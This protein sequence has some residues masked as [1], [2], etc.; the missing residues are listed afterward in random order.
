M[1]AAIFGNK[2]RRRADLE[3]EGDETEF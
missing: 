3:L 2:K 1:E